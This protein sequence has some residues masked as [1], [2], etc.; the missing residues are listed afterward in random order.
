MEWG[1][2]GEWAGAIAAGIGTL[3]SI[4]ALWYARQANQLSARTQADNRA[5]AAE[6]DRRQR[7]RDRLNDEREREFHARQERFAEEARAREQRREQRAEDQELRLVA[8][9]LQAWWVRRSTETA[10]T[11]WGVQIVNVSD[12]AVFHDVTV[13]ADGN[14]SA[15]AFTIELL[16]PGRFFCQSTTTGWAAFP[17]ALAAGEQLE[18]ITYTRKHRIRSIEFSDQLG[19]RW[20]WEPGA[21]PERIGTAQALGPGR[22]AGG[23][24]MAR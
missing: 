2:W 15:S 23:D 1:T 21:P 19:A 18:P 24:D 16:P 17:V 14:R 4:V 10:E 20:R 6:A 8:A 3:L 11:L 5:A 13:C 7:E 12:G 22:P 9:S